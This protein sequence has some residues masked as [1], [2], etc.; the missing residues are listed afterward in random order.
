METPLDDGVSQGVVRLFAAGY[1]GLQA[2]HQAASGD[3][4]DNI[5]MLAANLFQALEQNRS[6]VGGI[7]G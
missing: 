2:A 5:R 6:Q 7:G 3:T 4:T 1:Y